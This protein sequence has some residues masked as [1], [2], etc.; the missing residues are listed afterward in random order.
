MAK[1]T[2][3]RENERK[4]GLWT[5]EEDK[6]LIDYVEANGKGKWNTIAKRTG[7]AI[8]YTYGQNFTCISL[9]G[10]HS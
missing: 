8:N 6:I 10:M 2:N 4:K 1:A 7:S 5:E 3:G 9:E